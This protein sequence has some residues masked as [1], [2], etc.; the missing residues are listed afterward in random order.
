MNRRIMLVGPTG[1]GKTSLANVLNQ[2]ARPLRRGQD[3][4]YG[5]HTIDTPGAYMENAKM[6]KYLIMLAQTA[7][8]VLLLVDQASPH[9]DYPPGFSKVFT[10]PVLGVI[11]KTDLMPQN[12]KLCQR[13]LQQAGVLAPYI[14]FSIYDYQA[15]ARLLAGLTLS[16]E[17][18]THEI[19]YGDGATRPI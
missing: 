8:Q 16:R 13:Q 7:S 11:T 12:M 15:Q 6:R 1:S 10:C 2:T 4:I 5:T 18:R 9:I 19:R 3:V 17:G 14:K